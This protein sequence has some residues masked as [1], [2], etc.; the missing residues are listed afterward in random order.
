MRIVLF[1]RRPGGHAFGEDPLIARL[2]AEGHTVAGMVVERMPARAAWR[3]WFRPNEAA[4]GQYEVES[5]NS[6]A[7][8]TLVRSLKPDVIIL[9]G[10]GILKWPILEIPKWG[11]IVSHGAELPTYRGLDV[12]EWAILHGDPPAVSVHFAAEGVD[13]GAILACRRL[14]VEPGDTVARLREKSAALALDLLVEVLVK[15]QAGTS[16]P[17]TQPMTE[18]RQYFTMHPRLRRL[19]DERLKR[20][21]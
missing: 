18:G 9:R 5:H 11:T 7:C 6:S 12:T 8:V 13:T 4:P 20:S 15:L 17:R 19:A 2:A 1:S 10:C 14:P 16:A 3:D 21:A